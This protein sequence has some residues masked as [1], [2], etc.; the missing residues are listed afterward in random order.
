MG[1]GYQKTS[2]KHT[3]KA[4][5]ARTVYIKGNKSYVKKRCKTT[6]KMRYHEV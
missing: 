5:V 4:G 6:G 1:S 3:D 2:R